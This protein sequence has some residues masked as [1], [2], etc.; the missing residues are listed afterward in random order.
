MT[1]IQPN[2]NSIAGVGLFFV[3][4]AIL[5]L[6]IL[7]EVFAYS[8]TVSLKHD[9]IQ[10]SSEIEEMRLMSAEL[11]N[12]LYKITDQKNLDALA[13]ELGLVQDKNPKWVFASQF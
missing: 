2:K 10:L 6:G 1:V 13:K 12:D 7:V 8:Q 3:L 11:K 5:C 9:I 4:G